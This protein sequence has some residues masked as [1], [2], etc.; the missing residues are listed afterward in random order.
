M[1]EGR[2]EAVQDWLEPQSVK[3]IQVFLVL[4][5]F[6]RRFIRNFSRIAAPLTSIL[7]T[8]NKSTGDETQSTQLRIKM[9]QVLL[10]ELVVVELVE[11]SKICQPL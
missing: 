8:T 10:V 1:E 3:D 6:Y 2:I 9:H 5:N 4:A 7:W 11:V